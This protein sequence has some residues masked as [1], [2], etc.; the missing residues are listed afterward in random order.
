MAVVTTTT[1]MLAGSFVNKGPTCAF[2]I[3]SKSINQI[4]FTSNARYFA[5]VKKR[6]SLLPAHGELCTFRLHML[7]FQY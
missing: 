3:K 6:A 1:T 7:V 5:N 4:N 2:K